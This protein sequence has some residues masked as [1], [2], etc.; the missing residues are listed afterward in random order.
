MLTQLRSSGTD[1]SPSV[2]EHHTFARRAGQGIARAGIVAGLA[3]ALVGGGGMFLAARD[4]EQP[5][6]AA[7]VTAAPAVVPGTADEAG[8]TGVIRSLQARLRDVP[9]DWQSLAGL[10]AVY[11]EQAR[12]SGDPSYYPKAEQALQRSLALNAKNNY[13]ALSGLSILAAARHDFTAALDW[14][15]QGLAINGANATLH[16]ARTDALVEL[17]RFAEAQVAVQT[18]ADLR[19]DLPALVRASYLREL[20]GDT[21]TA[22]Q[23]M[24]DAE[25]D[26]NSPLELAFTRYHQG[27]LKE[28]AGRI[29]EAEADY[30]RARQADPRS[31]PAR[32]GLAR[33]AAARGRTSEA[34][35]AF[36]ALA[37]ERPLPAYAAALTELYILTGRPDDAARQR[38]LLTLQGKLAA[39]NGVNTDLE[40]ALYSADTGVGV[41]QAV[42]SLRV[43]W[44]RRKSIHVADALAWALYADGK[45]AEA[46]TYADE[47]LRIGTKSASFH[48]HRGMIEAALGDTAS[49]RRDLEAALRINPYFSLRRAAEA[50]ATLAGL[51]A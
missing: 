11:V 5:R 21:A 19:P 22:L 23:F 7:P 20:H 15:D 13:H 42:A 48:F 3:V 34:I 26:A 51:S 4:S 14:A 18:M 31:L 40:L 39:A 45:L 16:G 9:A 24:Q 50:R 44:S 49:A 10:G 46:K 29:D 36:E 27:E 38:E 25:R 1:G 41:P 2:P 30:T 28:S 8:L 47:A 17:G 33:I 6:T 35:A 12:V 37:N 43:E 32:E